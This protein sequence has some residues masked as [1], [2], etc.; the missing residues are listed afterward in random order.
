MAS[1]PRIL[2]KPPRTTQ[3]KIQRTVT[4]P[5]T[6]SFHSDFTTPET[7][8]SETEE[9][10]RNFEF[11]TPNDP[12]PKPQ[13]Y[14]FG[15]IALKPRQTDRISRSEGD[16]SFTA[17]DRIE[18]RIKQRKGGGS[19]LPDDTRDFMETRF[20][21]DFSSVRVHHD[22]E[23]VQLNRDLRAKAFTHGSDIYFNA[24]QYNPKSSGG[25]KLL[26][27]ELTHTIQQG[28]RKQL[29]TKP[30]KSTLQRQIQPKSLPI[31]IQRTPQDEENTTINLK[32]LATN[33]KPLSRD[34]RPLQAKLVV[35][36]PNDQY[37]QEADRVAEQVMAM[38]APPSTPQTETATPT[39]QRINARG[40]RRGATRPR[41]P[42][43]L[44]NSQE[45]NEDEENTNITLKPL[46]SA[47]IQRE[48]DPK[49][50]E[51][52]QPEAK[53]D[54]KEQPQPKTT[55]EGKPEDP[56]TQEKQGEGSGEG[57]NPTEG[58]GESNPEAPPP[59]EA[60]DT[61]NNAPATPS[62]IPQ[63][64]SEKAPTSPA[65]DPAFQAVVKQSETVKNQQSNTPSATEKTQKAQEAAEDPDQQ[66]REAQNTQLGDIK[67]QPAPPF[68]AEAFEQALLSKLEGIKPDKLEK[69]ESFSA[70]PVRNELNSQVSAEKEKSAGSLEQASQQSPNPDKEQP[71]PVTPIPDEVQQDV[72]KPPE[73]VDAEKAVPKEKGASE[74]EAPMAETAQNLD[75]TFGF[76]AKLVVGAPNDKYEQEAD[77]MADRV[78]KMDDPEEGKSETIQR[79]QLDSVTALADLIQRYPTAQIQRKTEI[80]PEKVKQ[81]VSEVPLNQKRLETYKEV[82]GDKALKAHAQAKEHLTQQGPQNYRDSEQKQLDTAKTDAKGQTEQ[83][84][85]AMYADR[86]QTMQDTTGKQQETKSKDEQQ[87][88]EITQKVQSIYNETKTQV[89]GRLAQLD[90][91]VNAEFEASSKTAKEKFDRY[92]QSRMRAYKARRY[93][94]F[95]GGAKWLKDKLFGLPGEVNRFYEDG[96]K[97]FIAELRKSI[98]RISEI[99]AT[100]LNEAKAL[101]DQGRQK[102]MD[103]VASLPENLREMGAES[104]AKIQAQFDSLEQQ[105]HDK[106]GQLIES[107]TAKYQK[108]LDDLDKEI[109]KLK[110]A[111][112]G[113]VSKVLDA[114]ADAAKWILKKLLIPIKSALAIFGID[115]SVLDGIIDDPGGFM[116]NL[117]KGLK[118][119]FLNFAKNIKKHLINGIATWLFGNIGPIEIPEKF[120]L[121]GF[122]N[123][124]LQ[125]IG[126]SK[127]AVVDVAK[128]SMG[129]LSIIVDIIWGLVEGGVSG[130]KQA[131]LSFSEEKLGPLAMILEGFIEGGIA[132]AKAAVETIGGMA[133][134]AFQFF[135]Q[136]VEDIGGIWGFIKENISILK[137][138][139]LSELIK[140][141]SIEVVKAGVMWILSMLNPASGMIKIVKAIVDVI[142][143][144]VNNY[145]TIKALV[146][147]IVDTLKSIVQGSPTVMSGIIEQTLANMIP[148]ALGFLVSLL[149]LSGI[150]GKIKKIFQKVSQ[151]FRKLLGKLFKK[152]SGFFKK[153]WGKFKKKVKKTYKKIKNKITGKDKKKK[154]RNETKAEKKKRKKA[155]KAERKRRL[156][157]ASGDAQQTVKSVRDPKEVKAKLP[158]IKS[159]HKLKSLKLK[160]P[161]NP[162]KRNKEY[163]I[164][165]K[166]GKVTVQKK[167]LPGSPATTATIHPEI[168]GKIARS[169]GRGQPL[170]SP[171]KKTME[172]A[173]NSD[174]S[175]TRIHHNPESD[176][177]NRSLDSQAFTVGND[178]FFSRGEYQPH[179]PPGQKLL[180]HELTHT[181]QQQSGKVVQR[182]EKNKWKNPK[183]KVLVKAGKI[184]SK[185]FTFKAQLLAEDKILKT[186]AKKLKKLVKQKVKPQKVRKKLASL[187]K[188]YQLKSLTLKDELKRKNKKKSKKKGSNSIKYKYTITAETPPSPTTKAQT[189]ALGS[190]SEINPTIE[191]AIQRQQGR[192]QALET[193]TQ[194]RMESAF[195]T[196]FSGV[197]IHHNPESDAL[198]RSLNAK[199]F[200]TGQDIFFRQGEYNPDNPIGQKL[201]AHELTH[202]LQQSGQQPKIQRFLGSSNSGLDINFNKELSSN[203]LVLSVVIAETQSEEEAE[204]ETPEEEQ[205]PKLSPTV[206]NSIVSVIKDIIDQNPD[207][208]IVAKKLEKVQVQ[209][210][211]D[212]VKLVTFGII[213]ESFTYTIKVKGSAKSMSI[214][215]IASFLKRL[216]GGSPKD[217]A[218]ADKP[219][220]PPQSPESQPDSASPSPVKSPQ[221]FDVITKVQRIDP[222]T[223]D[224]LVRANPKKKA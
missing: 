57:E 104:A 92:V 1:H 188:R 198:N 80:K 223:V 158:G 167:A 45:H 211:M 208:D 220:A 143:W 23:A 157:A 150:A 76:Q 119:G 133:K 159:Q 59:P 60:P 69:V 132:G 171:V 182:K 139:F 7:E 26:A 18:K 67:Q 145:D 73:G 124:F 37:E 196:D 39:I 122:F 112:K 180:A 105:V 197:R 165:G 52:P 123:I 178:I 43:F 4:L 84:L 29:Q 71:K 48:E 87:R 82:G 13:H 170:P 142:M 40:G 206:V 58:E 195:G 10:S 149:G 224:V 186:V 128:Q 94:G 216:G 90:K 168:E 136:L 199:A 44:V 140:M 221:Q 50:S 135:L 205:E 49:Q 16:G 20:G 46:D 2:V 42:Y 101:V 125:I 86:T 183:N 120:D 85:A 56:K 200:T 134:F 193:S 74:I 38:T 65:E 127:E 155:E 116:K 36:A 107:L 89:E 33:I 131:L 109:E 219:K 163:T 146:E 185:K 9:R 194:T 190:V 207:E 126:V 14:S 34:R 174:F 115:T 114:V 166:V 160:K 138:E 210:A 169:Q 41:V 153:I 53:S 215:K 222:T 137:T 30:L 202:T 17:G 108:S 129:S 70:E 8:N 192:G 47:L 148:T 106:Q 96:K 176:R 68:D 100:G 209:F 213:G 204:K 93:S 51:P 191:P 15:K 113:L 118:D 62:P 28:G 99:V 25:K 24:G 184:K 189:K 6:R 64:S 54:P 173:F 102:V 161:L 55:E 11:D 217:K 121:K 12:P 88:A 91:E 77:Q 172:R 147:S 63:G 151:T 22:S 110:E 79:S 130:A 164:E 35:G 187:K 81:P 103:Y 5:P 156:T 181:L 21:N 97:V 72:G 83:T 201:L 31:S 117:F 66:M 111:N 154:K 218:P 212:L 141:V 162:F 32:P 177:L 78:M 3:P 61:S 19:P 203:K 214:R 75:K 179:H 175:R 152:I 144:I 98:K 27:H 95:F